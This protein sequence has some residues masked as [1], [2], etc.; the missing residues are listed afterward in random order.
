MKDM[1]ARKISEIDTTLKCDEVALLWKQ[2]GNEKFHSNNIEESYDCYTKSLC[3]ALQDGH[4]FPVALANRS[5]A[6]MKMKQYKVHFILNY[7]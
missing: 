7:L 2:R 4:I 6:L 5:A 3:Y 1:F